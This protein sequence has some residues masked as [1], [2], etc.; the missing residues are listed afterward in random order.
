MTGIL[1]YLNN[2]LNHMTSHEYMDR[3]W[4]KFYVEEKG[5]LSLI[6]FIS[7][8]SIII[9]FRLFYPHGRRNASVVL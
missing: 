6:R 2:E 3:K 5:V 4:Q 7:F 9:H 1:E 8:L